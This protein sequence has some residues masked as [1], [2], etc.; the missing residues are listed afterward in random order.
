MTDREVVTYCAPTLAGLKTASL[1]TTLCVS[2]RET[3][4]EIC[5]MNR[6]LCDKGIRIIPLRCHKGRM[7]IYLYRPQMLQKDIKDENAVRLLKERGYRTDNTDVCVAQLAARVR[8]EAEFPHEIGLFLGYPPEDVEGFICHRDEDC[9]CVGCWRVYGD[10]DKARK[11]FDRYDRCT[12]IYCRQISLGKTLQEL[13][14]DRYFR[15]S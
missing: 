15:Q 5:R 13:T 12:D 3:R 8:K 10:A 11:Q 1:F 4:S 14:A 9:K 6:Q 2:E 7:L